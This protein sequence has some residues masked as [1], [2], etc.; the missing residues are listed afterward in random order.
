MSERE[1]EME[2]DGEM[3]GKRERD[4]GPGVRH[5]GTDA[6]STWPTPLFL[7]K[8]RALFKAKQIQGLNV[9][10]RTLTQPLVLTHQCPGLK[11]PLLS[12]LPTNPSSAVP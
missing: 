10:A 12:A 4:V 2:R 11:L 7:R 5:L 3:K 8:R 9:T 1:R 6:M